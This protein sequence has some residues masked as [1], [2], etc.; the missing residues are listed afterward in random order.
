MFPAPLLRAAAAALLLPAAAIAQSDP[1]PLPAPEGE[2]VL[3]VTGDIAVTNEGDAAVFDVAMLEAMDP[4]TIETT[5]IWTDGVQ[6][7]T[8][9]PLARLMEAVGAE[10]ESLSATAI[11]DYAVQIPSEDW[12]EDGPIVAYLANGEPMS[13]RTKGPLWIVY[14]YDD[15]AAYRS[16]VIYA[17]SIWQLDRIAVGD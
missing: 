6:T 3:T 11:N 2:V 17:R 10:G 5:T 7:F 8:G 13:V 15:V 16:E 9:V 12:V 14:P 4:V 1:A